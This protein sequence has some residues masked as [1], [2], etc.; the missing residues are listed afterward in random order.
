[1]SSLKSGALGAHSV[2]V[3]PAV[4]GT[5]DCHCR[6]H[7]AQATLTLVH[8]R[9]RS[10][11]VG[12]HHAFQTIRL[13][14]SENTAPAARVPLGS[15]GRECV[16]IGAEVL[17]VWTQAIP[18]RDEVVLIWRVRQLPDDCARKCLVAVSLPPGER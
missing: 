12:R 8:P 13:S 17:Q 6:A 4:V 16:V 1:M 18:C 5:V 11:R 3:K 9:I 7:D 14:A 2:T 15:G 10:E